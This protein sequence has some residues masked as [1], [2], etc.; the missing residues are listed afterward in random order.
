MRDRIRLNNVT[1]DFP[2]YDMEA[3]SIKRRLVLDRVS[4]FV[5]PDGVG[6]GGTVRR[7]RGAVLVRA[8]DGVSF[9]IADGDRVGLV[10]HNGAGKTTLL[11]VAAGIYEPLTGE[12]ITQG[13]VMPLLNIMEGISLDATGIEMIR[14]RGALLGLSDAELEEKTPEIIEFCEL[15]EYIEMPVRTYSTGMLVRLAFAIT[16]AVNSDILIM[17][18]IIGAGDAAFVER[19]QERLRRFVQQAS[20][21]LVASHSAEIVRQWCNKAMLLSHGRLIEFGSVDSVLAHYERLARTSSD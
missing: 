21:L 20:V 10:G 15:G 3:R 17:D 7:D 14:L 11:R 16:T 19:A 9:A 1:V 6:V 2:I 18:E 8:L 4:S 5:R 13:R 12:V